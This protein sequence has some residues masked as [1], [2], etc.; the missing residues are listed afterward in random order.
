MNAITILGSTGSIGVSTLKVLRV[1]TGEYQVYGLS[2][3]KNLTLFEEQIEEFHP[4][5]V[6]VGSPEV[7]RSKSFK[8]LKNKFPEIE[9]LVGREGIEELA[10]REVD[11]LVSA[12]VGAA[13]LR[14]TLSAVPHVRRIALANKETLVMAGDIFINE[15]KAHKV[16]L[17][18]IDSEH[19]AILSLI[20]NLN[21][22]DI[23]R[24]ILTA[25]GGSLRDKTIKEMRD[26]TPDEALAHPN[27]NMGSKITI[28][29]ATMMNKG[30]EVIEAHHL[31][32]IDYNQIEVVIHPESIIHS[33]VETSDGALF[34]HMG[35]PDMAHPI[36]Y[37]LVYPERRRN[38]FGRLDL[39][40][41]KK[42]SF[43][44][45]DNS[46]YPA[47]KLCFTAGKQGGT[48]PAV[49]NAANEVAV[50][51]FLEKRILFTDII[52]IVEKTLEAHEKVDNPNISAIF[53]ADSWARENARSLIRG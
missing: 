45:F 24:I 25:S 3:Q 50:D 29:S 9:F 2:C 19:S 4:R 51:A 28:D 21:P 1:L 53:C 11:V 49:L 35:V 42:L 32:E 22:K 26:V 23:A 27:W 46:R 5:V 41:I 16:E 10:S 8:N 17:I 44:P 43:S 34:A 20:E 14:P 31:F 48:M 47:L 12:I 38:P 39:E 13:A 36:L 15:V 6:A 33:M 37:S 18:P 40:T 30:L 52:T 7:T